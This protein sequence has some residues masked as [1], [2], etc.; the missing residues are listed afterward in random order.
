MY[1]IALLLLD[2][3][4][5]PEIGTTAD[6]INDLIFFL[7]LG[8]YIGHLIYMW[9]KMFPTTKKDTLSSASSSSLL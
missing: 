9:K 3:L 2:I 6:L 7:T 4:W 5:Y 8:L 1:F